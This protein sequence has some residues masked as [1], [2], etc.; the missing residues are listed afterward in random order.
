MEESNKRIAKNTIYLYI[1]Q[2]VIMALS[3]VTT[4]VVLDKLGASDYGI[5]NLVGGFV[6]SFAVLNS[7]LSSG[8]RRFLALYLGKG[9]E[10]KLRVTFSTALVIHLVIAFVVVLA[11]ESGGLWFLNSKLNI[12]PSRMSAANWVFQ[13]AMIGVFL[14]IVQ[15]PYMA[16]VTAHERFNVYATMSI[17]DVV[18]KL[19]VIYILIYLPGDK[20]IIYS[21]LQLAVIST[22][23]LIYRIYCTRQFPEC[24]WSLHIDKPLMKEMLHFSGWGVLG[25]VITVVNNQGMS[26]ILNLFFNTVMNAA[27]GLAQTVNV[28][29]S[30]FITGFLAA[31]QP[32]LVKFYG[33]GEMDRFVRLIFNVTQYT[34]FLIGIIVIPCVLEID[35]VV[36]LWLGNE[37]PEYTCAFIKITLACSLI[38]RSNAMVEDGLIAIGRVKENNMYSV[39]VYLLSIPLY[40]VAMKYGHSAILAYWLA[41]VPPLL[42]FIINMVLLS[43]Y[44]IFPG[45]KFFKSVF[46]KNIFLIL[47]SAIVPFAV[48][49]AMQPGL[50]RFF[51]V[52][53]VSVLSTFIVLWKWGMNDN[54]RAML[55]NMVQTKFISKFKR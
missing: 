15:T 27:R 39:P 3:F 54:V 6:A 37:V 17:F 48:Q 46:L 40:Y 51:V 42:S 16:A 49:Q 18:A 35:Y 55:A 26:I 28:V 30:Q 45:M 44:T 32:Q 23:M 34:L 7:I 47:I 31:A 13:F 14:N 24:K 25:H 33:A 10:S 8:T 1:R 50:V 41:S 19:A 21:A 43:K 38:Y 53:A 12:D 2:L 29:I 9:D 52:C 20:L 22:G 36:G 4:R 11:L 5:N